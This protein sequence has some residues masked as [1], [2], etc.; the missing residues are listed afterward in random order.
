MPGWGDA[1][2]DGLYELDTDK[3]LVVAADDAAS[4]S[5][6][7]PDGVLHMSGYGRGRELERDHCRLLFRRALLSVCDLRAGLRQWRAS[8]WNDVDP[9]PF[10]A[11]DA[12]AAALERHLRAAAAL[13]GAAADPLGRAM[14]PRLA[15]LRAAFAAAGDAMRR[16]SARF[17]GR[18]AASFRELCAARLRQAEASLGLVEASCAAGY[19]TEDVGE[20]APAPAGDGGSGWQQVVSHAQAML[21]A[22]EEMLQWAGTPPGGAGDDDDAG[23]AASPAALRV[24]EFGRVAERCKLASMGVVH[25]ASASH[26][27]PEPWVS[28]RDIAAALTRC[29]FALHASRTLDALAKQAWRSRGGALL[30]YAAAAEQSSVLA[31]AAQEAHAQIGK[32]REAVQHRV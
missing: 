3:N 16:L 11:A 28:E 30:S 17:G 24:E 10:L 2:S 25:V 8:L 26:C 14:P 31:G 5:A 18:V 9:P 12:A 27:V 32:M 4:P 15:A 22:S 13:F 20:P 19:R 23:T 6:F 1:E 29:V 21:R 7:V